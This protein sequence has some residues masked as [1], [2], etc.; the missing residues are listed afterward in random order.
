MRTLV[1]LLVTAIVSSASA[2]QVDGISVHGRS[3]VCSVSDIR[4]AIRAVHEKVLRVKVL[5]ADWMHVY[6]KPIDLGWIAVRRDP[7]AKD[8]TDHTW[9][10]WFCS[11]R[12]EDDP[13]VSQFMR[14]ANEL[15][16]FPVMTPDEPRRDRKR[17]RLVESSARRG[18]STYSP[19]I[20]T[21]IRGV[22]RCSAWNPNHET[23]A[24]YSGAATVNSCYSSLN[25]F[26]SSAGLI[27]GTFNGAARKQY[28]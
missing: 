6:F 14:I 7:Y 2:L 21:G 15:Y 25:S 17:M 13:E 26:T 3:R 20:R 16:V 18:S 1:V 23:S 11:G 12:G 8:R 24:S 22:I 10:G 9:P 19:T 5:S 28:A 27:Q 4:D